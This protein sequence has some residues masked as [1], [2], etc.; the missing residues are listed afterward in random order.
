MI[1]FITDRKKFAETRVKKYGPVFTTHLFFSPCVYLAGP[2][3]KEVFKN[4]T[5]AWPSTWTELLGEHSMAVINGEPH[6]KQRSIAAKA[7][8]PEALASYVPRLQEVTQKHLERWAEKGERATERYNPIDDIQKYTFEIAEKL[9]LGR[10]T[11]E[12]DKGLVATFK[13]W[14]AGYEALVPFNLPFTAHGK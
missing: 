6:K 12:T 14:L 7:F 10:S 11:G 1:Q 2:V 8:T 3:C 5:I 4:R 13:I 9:L